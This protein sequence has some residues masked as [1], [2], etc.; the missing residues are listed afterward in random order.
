[1][2]YGKPVTNIRLD[3]QE[4]G[5]LLFTIWKVKCQLSLLTLIVIKAFEVDFFR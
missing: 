2:S 3:F 1:M 5:L 4:S